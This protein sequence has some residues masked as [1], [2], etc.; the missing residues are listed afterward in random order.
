MLLDERIF[1]LNKTFLSPA[2][3]ASLS[4]NGRYLAGGSDQDSRVAQLWDTEKAGATIAFRGHTDAVRCVRFS[5]D[6]QFIATC[7]C[8]TSAAGYSHE[9]IVWNAGTG[10]RL[11]TIA[12]KGRV[13]NLAF[14]P[15]NRLLAFSG[16]YG[17]V[18]LATWNSPQKNVALAG[19]DGDVTGLA[20]SADGGLLASAGME[21]RR[22]KLWKV[23]SIFSGERTSLHTMSA[24]N[25]VCDLAFSPDGRRLAAASRDMV[26]LWD[27]DSGHEAL[28]LR[29]A[30]QRF[31]DPDFNPRVAFSPDGAMLAGTNWNESIS[32]W[33]APPFD[34]GEQIAR[35]QES[36]RQ[37]S[38]LRSKL[39]H[40]QEAELCMQYKNVVSARFHLSFVG[41]DVQTGLLRS[42]KDRLDAAIGF[43]PKLQ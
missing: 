4:K 10:E 8:P 23:A 25:L 6:A 18:S 30:T 38:E 21:D 22:V 28:T 3:P 41:N 43:S 34:N 1:P 29:G 2:V 24:P 39:W 32:L 35:F 16:Q 31:W 27:V 42:R 11:T 19:H 7:A 14:S 13:F 36:R 9:I 17:S 40:L 33:Q 20:F 37:F 12:G 26:K 15:D 5:N